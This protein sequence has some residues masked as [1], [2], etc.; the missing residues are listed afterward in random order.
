MLSNLQAMSAILQIWHYQ[1][2]AELINDVN[3]FL[4]LYIAYHSNFDGLVDQYENLLVAKGVE[5][6]KGVIT[7]FDAGKA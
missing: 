5:K 6:N 3:T 4:R 1:C 7:P 2:R